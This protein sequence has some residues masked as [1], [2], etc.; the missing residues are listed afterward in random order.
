MQCNFKDKS[1]RRRFYKTNLSHGLNG[2]RNQVVNRDN[3][4]CQ[5]CKRYGKSRT[6]ATV[7]HCNPLETY[8]S[9]RLTT[10]TLLSLCSKCHEAM[11]DRVN[12]SLTA[13]GVLV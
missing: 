6:V 4:E 12:D 3:I 2:V 9:L 7:H 10:W 5:E 11:H 8:P 13:L 1:K